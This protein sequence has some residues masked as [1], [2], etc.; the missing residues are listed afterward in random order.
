LATIVPFEIHSISPETG[1]KDK[2]V[3]VE[4]RGIKLDQ[5]ERFRLR[6]SDPWLEVI[7]HEVFVRNDNRVYATFDLTGIEEDTFLLDG[8]KA[9]QQLAVAPEPFI[10][11]ASGEP[12]L[13]LSAF[14]PSIFNAAGTPSK[15]VINFINAGDADVI[16]AIVEVE[17]PYVNRIAHTL[18]A[19][20]NGEGGPL[21]EVPLHEPNGPP[22]IIRPGGSG[23]IEVYVWSTP[24]PSFVVGLKEE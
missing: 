8:V 19:I 3:T 22:G 9:N 10:V 7:A 20:R 13:Q 21:L 23:T 2:Q 6:R 24:G 18:E 4:I 15:L 1:V 14:A 5:T 12:D 17:S 11:V 16:D